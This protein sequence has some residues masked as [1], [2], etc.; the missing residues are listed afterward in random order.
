MTNYSSLASIFRSTAWRLDVA[1]KKWVQV[2]SNNI[3]EN[4]LNHNLKEHHDRNR[5]LKPIIL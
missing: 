4:N 5:I 2:G 3:T 1:D